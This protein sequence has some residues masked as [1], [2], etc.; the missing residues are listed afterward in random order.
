MGAASIIATVLKVAPLGI[1]VRAAACKLGF[2][3]LGC[4]APLCPLAIGQEATDGC[5][6]TGNT[7]EVKA[8]ALA[9]LDARVPAQIAV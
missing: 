9:T 7:A 6:P 4:D 3:I 2:P 8:W 1:Y 5:T